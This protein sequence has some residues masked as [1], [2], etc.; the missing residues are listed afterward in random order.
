MPGNEDEGDGVICRR[1]LALELK[2]GSL[3][4]TNIQHQT[5]WPVRPLTAEKLLGGREGLDPPSHGTNQA[6]EP[7]AHRGVIVHHK[8]DGIGG[9]RWRF[10]DPPSFQTG[11]VNWKVTPEPRCEVAQSLPPCA[12]TIERLMASPRPSPCGLVV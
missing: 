7:L 6:V 2:P 4:Q 9:M 1:Q 8:Y 12:S 11:R 10:H 5:S 3:G